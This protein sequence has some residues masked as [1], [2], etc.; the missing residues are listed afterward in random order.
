MKLRGVREGELRGLVGHGTADFCD[1]VAVVDYC[2][3]AGGIEVAAAGLVDDPTA[4]A[5]DGDWVSISEISREERGVGRHDGRQIV[6]EGELA[7]GKYWRTCGIGAQRR[8]SPT[9]E[10]KRGRLAH[11][12]LLGA[13]SG[14]A[15]TR[16]AAD[17]WAMEP[18]GSDAQYDDWGEHFW[19]AFAD[20]S[21]TGA[22]E[23]DCLF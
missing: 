23:S 5:A 6:A 3:L 16:I 10:R 18:R 7:R 2:G 19:A 4:L 22:V 14:G 15:T 21:S 1:A 8:C 20:C 9:E 13:A 12:F 17:N 11:V